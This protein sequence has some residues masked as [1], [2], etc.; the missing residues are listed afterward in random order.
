M[1]PCTLLE[2]ITQVQ[3]LNEDPLLRSSRREAVIAL[4]VFLAA[5]TYTIVY[6]TYFGYHRA[7]GEL[8]LVWGIPSWVMWGVFLPWGLCTLFNCWFSAVVMQDHKLEEAEVPPDAEG[9]TGED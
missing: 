4:S 8:E 3:P 7:E 1:F 5:L 2:R 9:M 6:C